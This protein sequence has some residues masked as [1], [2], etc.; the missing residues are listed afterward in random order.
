[1]SNRN[2]YHRAGRVVGRCVSGHFVKWHTIHFMISRRQ[3]RGDHCWGESSRSANRASISHWQI[4]FL[5]LRVFVIIYSTTQARSQIGN[6][7]S[8]PGTVFYSSR[9]RTLCCTRRHPATKLSIQVDP[10]SES[11]LLVGPWALVGVGQC[12]LPCRA[13]SSS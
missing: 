11:A 9:P 4:S 12:T 10:A 1:M 8:E 5:Q 3:G 13:L 6:S 7:T 2:R